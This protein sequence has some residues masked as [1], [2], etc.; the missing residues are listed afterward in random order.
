MLNVQLTISENVCIEEGR[1]QRN[2][3]KYKSIYS[4]VRRI[5]YIYIQMR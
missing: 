5:I 2:A 1:E 4:R 3:V